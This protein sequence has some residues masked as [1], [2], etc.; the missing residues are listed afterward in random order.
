[1]SGERPEPWRMRFDELK[2]AYA[3]GALSEDER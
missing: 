1:M 3:L 2:E